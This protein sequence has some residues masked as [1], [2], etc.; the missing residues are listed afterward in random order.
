[1][2]QQRRILLMLQKQH[3]GVADL[4]RMQESKK[5]GRLEGYYDRVVVAAAAAVRIPSFLL[6]GY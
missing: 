4:G 2:G 3:E 6:V 1:M 5:V